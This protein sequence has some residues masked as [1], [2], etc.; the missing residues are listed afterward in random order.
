MADGIKKANDYDLSGSWGYRIDRAKKQHK[1]Q[2]DTFMLPDSPCRALFKGYA[3][4]EISL[5]GGNT[6]FESDI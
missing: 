2:N 1:R 5:R 6:R 4:E 3:P